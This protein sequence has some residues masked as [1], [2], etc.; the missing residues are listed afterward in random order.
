[1]RLQVN[2]RT[3][4]ESVHEYQ[5][6][7]MCFLPGRDGMSLLSVACDGF[8]C[9]LDIETGNRH[10]LANLNPEGWVD[11][12]S[13]EKNWNMFQACA[14]HPA[15]PSTAWASDNQGKVCCSAVLVLCLCRC[16]SLA[17][18]SHIPCWWPDGLC[19]SGAQARMCKLCE[20]FL[21]IFWQAQL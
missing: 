19:K 6:N 15:M 17:R 16:M 5:V 9:V 8:A 3:V 1:M 2:E 10:A 21:I 7:S 14:V 13:N 12:V 4:F 18:L 11:G 20:P